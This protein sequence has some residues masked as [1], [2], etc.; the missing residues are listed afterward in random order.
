MVLIFSLSCEELEQQENSS[1]MKDLAI[2]AND[3][4]IAAQIN[5]KYGDYQNLKISDA[6]KNVKLSDL[7]K[8]QLTESGKLPEIIG[9]VKYSIEFGMDNTMRVKFNFKSAPTADQLKSLSSTI[10]GKAAE[11][12]KLGDKQYALVVRN[13]AAPQ[14]DTAHTFTISD[15]KNTYTTVRSG[16]SYAYSIIKS[17]SN[18]TLIDLV[19]AFYL[20]NLY[21]KAANVYFKE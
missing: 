1:A 10:D 3:Y 17:S 12:E 7:E 5:F 18:E 2:A 14:I 6:V 13:I 15:G 4:G 8:Y 11:L 9:N 19:K 16:L 21:N 20:Y